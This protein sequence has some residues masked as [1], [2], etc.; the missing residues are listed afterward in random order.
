[1]H[2]DDFNRVWESIRS[3]PK[4]ALEG[5]MELIPAS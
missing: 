2:G 3:A 1:M 4:V 5:I